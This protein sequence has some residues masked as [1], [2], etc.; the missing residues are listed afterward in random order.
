MGVPFDTSLYFLVRATLD[1]AQIQAHHALPTLNSTDKH[2]DKY[3][4]QKYCFR[5]ALSRF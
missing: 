1:L 3:R 2:P 4:N 5:I